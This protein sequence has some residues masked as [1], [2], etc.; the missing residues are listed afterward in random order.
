[1]IP[2]QQSCFHGLVLE[3][4]QVAQ[5]INEVK[6]RE[7]QQKEYRHYPQTTGAFRLHIPYSSLCFSSSQ[8]INHVVKVM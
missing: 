4:Q 3:Y 2:Y 7:K 6:Q 1:M 5:F 8:K